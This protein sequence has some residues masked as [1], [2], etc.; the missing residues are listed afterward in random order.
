LITAPIL[1]IGGIAMAIHQNAGLSWL[2]AVSV[3]VLAATTYLVVVKVRPFF[4]T[5]QKLVD[6]INNVMREQLSGVKVIRAFV[7]QHSE[8]D[9]FAKVNQELSRTYV[10]AGRWDKLMVPVAM[11][12]VNL[13]SVAVVWFGGLRINA[14]EMQVGSLIAFLSYFMQILGAAVMATLFFQELP[15]ASVCAGRIS[16]VLCATPT[17]VSPPAGG[18]PSRR[19]QGDVRLDKVTFCYR[20]ADHPTLQDVSLT[21]RPGTTTAVVG[22]SGSGKSTLV[23][24]ICRLYDV[25]SGAVLVDGVDVRDYGTEQLWSAIG[26]VPQRGYL[27]SGTVADN[28]RYGKSDA[29]DSEMW[30]ALRLAA[31]DNFVHAHPDGLQMP[32][33][34]GGS[35]LSG[36]QRQMLAIARAVISHPAIYLFDDAFSALDVHS[37]AR[38]RAS[39]REVS[40]HSTV[41]IVAQ[42]I[43]TVAAADQIVVLDEGKVVGVG[44]HGALLINCPTYAEL[45]NLQS[46]NTAVAGQE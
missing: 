8:R 37:D 34:Q 22:S 35:N 20:G 23:S 27:F 5:A 9:H 24:L 32:I 33:A 39:L 7:R 21:A 13:S 15:R 26:L 4:A 41:I 11:L 40:A 46:L 6:T 30:E 29:S 2:L 14:G 43:S 31:A 44:R 25:T 36:G 28:L 19:I 1:G 42:R 10:A 45:A 17:I 16:E 3:P 38:I 12:V 18:Q